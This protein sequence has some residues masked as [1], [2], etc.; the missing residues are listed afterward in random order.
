[1]PL[2]DRP[3]SHASIE[4]VWGQAIH[5]YTF[6]PAGCAASGGANAGIGTSFSTLAIDTAIDDPGG[7][8]DVTG[9]DITI[10]TGGEGL[11]H[12][13]VDMNTVSGSAGSGFGTRGVI[14]LNG[15]V[16][17]AGKEDNNGATNVRFNIPWVGELVAGDVLTFQAQKIG[18]G[19]APT[20][21]LASVI[22]Y[23][24]GFEFGAP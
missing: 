17:A 10:P 7:Y 18:G 9:N 16:V 3:V 5:D 4:S 1:M 2:P 15:A 20:V 19:T 11:Y 13:L 24:V 22:L 6:A 23:R 8:V 21:S 12:I 14:L